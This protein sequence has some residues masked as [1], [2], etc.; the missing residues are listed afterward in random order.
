MRS[1]PDGYT[2]LLIFQPT[3]STRPSTTSSAS[4]LSAISRRSPESPVRHRHG[5]P[6]L[7]A[8]KTF[9]FIAYAK[10]QSRHAFDQRR[11]DERAIV[12]VGDRSV[13]SRYRRESETDAIRPAC[14]AVGAAGAAV[15]DGCLQAHR[16]SLAAYCTGQG[17]TRY[18]ASSSATRSAAAPVRRRPAS[19]NQRTRSMRWDDA[20]AAGIFF[21]R[22]R[23]RG[24]GASSAT[25]TAGAAAV[26]SL[27]GVP[28][29]WGA[30]T[31]RSGGGVSILPRMS[32]DPVFRAADDHA[33][34]HS[35]TAP[36]KCR[37]DAAP[38]QVRIEI[39]WLTIVWNS[40]RLSASIFCAPTALLALDA[41]F[42]FFPDVVCSVLRVDGID[43]E[44]RQFD[45]LHQRIVED[46]GVPQR[47]AIRRVAFASIIFSLNLSSARLRIFLNS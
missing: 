8:G 35:W 5:G 22:F 37:L 39:L 21:R 25:A 15:S 44:R 30:G 47:N 14:S 43:H 19:A 13:S 34:S 31:V 11:P 40:A 17:A 27:D 32:G 46:D 36:P 45:A 26:V 18:P 23:Q 33:P 7:G 9:E 16:S 10:A 2:L 12:Q 3:Q 20:S 28:P 42:E 4:I 24:S 41:E 38:P 6:S 1:Q 29:S